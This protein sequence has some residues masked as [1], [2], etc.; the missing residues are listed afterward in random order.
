MKDKLSKYGYRYPG[1]KNKKTTLIERQKNRTWKPQ[2]LNNTVHGYEVK[3]HNSI[4]TKM[5]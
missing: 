1:D 4:G 5:T 2:G 3:R